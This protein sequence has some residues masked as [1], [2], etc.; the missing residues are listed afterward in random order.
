VPVVNGN[1]K[2]TCPQIKDFGFKSHYGCYLAKGHSICDLPVSDW[3]QVVEIVSPA[4]L[5]GAVFTQILQ[6]AGTCANGILEKL[7]AHPKFI[8]TP[9]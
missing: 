7:V 3:I 9:Q 6:V 4:A 8:A 2:L 5:N 1:L